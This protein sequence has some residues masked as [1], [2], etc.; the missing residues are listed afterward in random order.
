[1]TY[2]INDHVDDRIYEHSNINVIK[3]KFNY[4]IS[5]YDHYINVDYKIID[6]VY[7]IYHKSI[8][9]L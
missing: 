1:M 8:Y 7:H 9:K 5:R 2:Y 6:N 4:L 3:D